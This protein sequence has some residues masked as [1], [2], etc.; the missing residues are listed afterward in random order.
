[1]YTSVTP[2]LMHDSRSRKGMVFVPKHG[3][4]HAKA[5]IRHPLGTVKA[6]LNIAKAHFRH[7]LGTVLARFRHGLGT[8]IQRWALF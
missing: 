2:F 8:N 5:Q 3:K 1:M 6:H 7:S 4:K